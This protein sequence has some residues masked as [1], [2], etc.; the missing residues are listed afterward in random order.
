[1]RWRKI[2]DVKKAVQNFHTGRKLDVFIIIVI[3][4]GLFQARS[5]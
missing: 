3:I 4:I 5:P 1:M 2:V